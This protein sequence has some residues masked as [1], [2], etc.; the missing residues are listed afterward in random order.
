MTDEAAELQGAAKRRIVTSIVADIAVR[1]AV[2]DVFVLNDAAEPIAWPARAQG[3][4]RSLQPLVDMYF[5]Q[6]AAHRTSLTEL[7]EVDGALMTVRIV[8]YHGTAE[9]QYALMVEPFVVRSRNTQGSGEL[10]TS[11]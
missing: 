5:S 1:R 9:S 8:P 2:P 7:I 4:P 6:D 3:I 10:T 11:S